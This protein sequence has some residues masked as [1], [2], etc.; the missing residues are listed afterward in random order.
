MAHI[1]SQSEWEEEM[2][3]KILQFVRHELYLDLRF[4]E[5]ALLALTYRR[6]DGLLTFATDGRYLYVSPEWMIRV[7]C[8]NTLFLDRAYLHTVLHCLFRHLWM[9]KKRDSRLWHVACDIAA[10][11]VIDALNRG[12]TKRI[13]GWIRKNTYDAIQ[14]ETGQISAAV[15]YRWLKTKEADQLAAIEREF[16]TDDHRFWPGEEE[17]KQPLLRQAGQDWAKRA[18]QTRLLQNRR[19]DDPK[20]GEEAFA[21]QIRAGK[22]RR[23]Y[24]DFLRKF[25]VFQEEARLDP[26][27]FD[28]GYYSYGL[29]LYGSLPLIEP[30]ETRETCKICDFVIVIDTSYSTSGELV[31]GFLKEAASVLSQKNSFFET[32]SIRIIQ[33]DD[34]VQMDETISA[35]EDMERLLTRFELH[36]GGGTDFRPAFTY[37]EKLREEGE[38]SH[39]GGLLYFTD[40]KGIYPQKKPDYKTAFLF[41]GEYDESAVPPWAMRL[42]LEPEELLHEY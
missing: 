33:C 30:L 18:R 27:E 32:Y 15:I 26:E 25:A 14:Q 3:G 6:T 28:L 22:G 17:L 19:G 34:Q 23:S 16:Y 8:Q 21:T 29:R 11:H 5:P 38:L 12:C 9:G 37:V 1:Q 36:G 10:E 2:A 13:I 24:A 41:L 31:E 42:Q 40:G 39:M 4:L 20:E 7:F 35:G